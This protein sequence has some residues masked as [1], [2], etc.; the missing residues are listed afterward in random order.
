MSDSPKSE[1][2]LPTSVRFT[3]DERAQVERQAAGMSLSDYIRMRVFD[4]TNPPAQR[5][6]KVPIRDHTVLAK[7][8]ALLGASRIPNNLNQLARA[9]NSGSLV[10]TPDIASELREALHHIADIR[11]AIFAALGVSPR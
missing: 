8:L 7:A 3:A 11:H 10:L 6:N 9:S 2:L 4:P 1:K 5:R